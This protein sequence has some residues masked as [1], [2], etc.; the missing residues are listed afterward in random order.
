MNQKL[1]KSWHQ[2][3][4]GIDKR[5]NDGRLSKVLEPRDQ[6]HCKA[7]IFTNRHTGTP[8]GPTAEDRGTE[9]AGN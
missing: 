1:D 5:D 8:R 2:R 4:K 3:H 6:K 7:K 9:N